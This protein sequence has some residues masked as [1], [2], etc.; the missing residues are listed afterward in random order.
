MPWETRDNPDRDMRYCTG[1]RTGGLK[2]LDYNSTAR[3][4]KLWHTN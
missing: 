4:L 2:P 3:D 1:P